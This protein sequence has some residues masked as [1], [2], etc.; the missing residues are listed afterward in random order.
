MKKIRLLTPFTIYNL[1]IAVLMML[2][3]QLNNDLKLDINEL[4]VLKSISTIFTDVNFSVM[5]NKRHLQTISSVGCV[6]KIRRHKDP[7]NVCGKCKL[8][9]QQASN[10]FVLFKLFLSTR[11]VTAENFHLCTILYCPNNYKE[12]FPGKCR[13]CACKKM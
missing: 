11:C 5:T 9:D 10:V 12:F 6:W 8:T 2:K 4:K 7:T 1:K 3:N 13:G